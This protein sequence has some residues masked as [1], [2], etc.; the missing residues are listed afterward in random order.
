MKGI[1]SLGPGSRRVFI[2]GQY[3][4]IANALKSAPDE[5]LTVACEFFGGS[6][7]GNRRLHRRDFVIDL[8]SFDE[9][10]T[11]DAPARKIHRETAKIAK[12]VGELANLARASALRR[13]ARRQASAREAEQQKG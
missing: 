1:R 8:K 12:A 13:V 2:W 7:F 11:R 9:T 4:G 5:E 10:I 3:G 6:P